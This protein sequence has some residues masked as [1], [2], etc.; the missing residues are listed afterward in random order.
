MIVHSEKKSTIVSPASREE[1]RIGSAGST[2]ETE[3]EGKSDHERFSF[4]E[5]DDEPTSKMSSNSVDPGVGFLVF[6]RKI[7][8]EGRA[9]KDQS[10]SCSSKTP[11]S[12]KSTYLFPKRTRPYIKL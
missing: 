4:V 1:L 6:P 10:P 8:D 3:R 2:R 5:R 7:L 9:R 12:L 11:L